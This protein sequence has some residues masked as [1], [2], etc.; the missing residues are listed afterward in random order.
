MNLS[1]ETIAKLTNFATIQPNLVYKGDRKIKTISDANNVMAVAEIEE[2]IDIEFGVYDLNEFLRAVGLV[3]RPTLS[4]KDSHAVIQGDNVKVEYQFANT[5]ILTAPKKDIVMPDPEVELELTSDEIAK[6][7]RA[8]S[9]F[10]YN[11]LTISHRAGTDSIQVS[12]KDLNGSA[13]GN[14]YTITKPYNE[15]AN[16]SE[17]FSFDVL[18]SNLKIMEGDY[19]VAFS[20]KRISQWVGDKVTYWIALETT[21]TYG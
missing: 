18:I 10:G 6:I 14:T 21:S 17:A 4:F 16:D 7:L 1:N 13:G 20:S 19:N 9:T 5:A 15:D 8:A 2:D 12:V 3:D 11:G